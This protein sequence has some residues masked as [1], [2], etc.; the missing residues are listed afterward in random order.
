MTVVDGSGPNIHEGVTTLIAE[1][2][3]H[4]VVDAVLTSSAVVAHEM[5]GTL[6]RVR[7]VRPAEHPHLEMPKHLL[8]R[9][10][11]FEVTELSP[12]Q[13]AAIATE[14]QQG[15]DVYE[16]VLAVGGDSLIKA[17][18][19]MA[20]PMGPRTERLAREAEV[21]AKQSGLSLER[22]VGLGAD[23]RTMIGAGA[24][25]N[26]PVLVSIPQLVGGGAVGL[27]IGDAI[28]IT[29]RSRLVAEALD[30]SDVI[31]ESAM[32]SPRKFMMDLSSYTQ[33][34]ESGRRGSRTIRTPLEESPGANRSRYQSRAGLE[35]R[36]RERA[37]AA[38]GGSRTPKTKLTGIRSAWKCPV[39]RVS[40]AVSPLLPISEARG[41]YSPPISRPSSGW[42][43]ISFQHRR[44][45]RRA[46]KCADG[47][48]IRFNLWTGDE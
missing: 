31:I 19:N 32:H 10:G 17:A 4:D 42:S 45:L 28:S 43:S 30:K 46:R 47:S 3:R 6:D 12:D 14:I 2:I 5:A 26:R 33:V 16:R 48:P 9:G 7:R 39:L 25:K 24:A 35:K 1:L 8:P 37:G 38:G 21:L 44:K 36:A 20:W 40:K 15:W 41:R 29:R 23:L 34:T 11:V 13:R 27:A 22:A 18:G